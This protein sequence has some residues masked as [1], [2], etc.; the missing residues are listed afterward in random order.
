MASLAH[1]RELGWEACVATELE[2]QLFDETYAQAWD[3]G[4]QRMSPTGR[5]NND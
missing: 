4:F 3:K 1:L 5:G 2:F